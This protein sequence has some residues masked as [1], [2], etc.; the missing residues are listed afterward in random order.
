MTASVSQIITLEEFLNLPY[1]EDSP[2]W[3]YEN[4][5]AIQ[6]PISKFRHSIIQKRLLRAVDDNSEEYTALP[7]LRCTFAGRSIVPDVAIVAWNR[8][9]LNEIGEPVDNFEQPPDWTIEILSP[10]QKATRVIDNILH[11]LQNGCRLGWLIDPDDYSILI[12]IPQKEP[13]IFR[14]NTQLQV[15]EGIDLILTAE[16]VFG[17]LKVLQNKKKSN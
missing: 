7:E 13:K 14:G 9:Q 12:F 6:K 11:C 17:W 2:A 4:G 8:I 15:L 3:E 10:D 1:I 5:V 16:E